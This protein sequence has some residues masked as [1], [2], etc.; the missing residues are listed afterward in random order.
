MNL[1]E[2]GWNAYFENQWQQC[3]SEDM[4]PG[5]VIADYG[6]KLRVVLEQGEVMA[7]R[8]VN[9]GTY[10]E[11][12]VVGDWVVVNCINNG[13]TAVI[14][15]VLTRKTAFTRAA[16]GRE[17]KQQVVAA[18]IEIVFLIQSLNR[19]FNL[20]RMERYLIAAWESGAIPVIVLTKAD[21]SSSAAEKVLEVQRTA[22]GTD[23]HVVS[24]VTGQGVQE[25]RRYFQPGATVALLGSSGVGKSTLINVLAGE[26][27][28][29]TQEIRLN[30]A[31]GR[32][33]TTHREII[34]LPEGGLVMDT[35]GM[36]ALQLWE[37][38]AGMAEVFGDIDELTALCRFAD[39]NHGYEPG[40]AVREALDTGV[41]GQER[42]DSWQKLQRE[43]AFIEAKKTGQA[44]LYEKRWS[45][46]IAKVSKQIK[47]VNKRK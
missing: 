47:K 31:R 33:T 25:I 43:L 10:K 45:K 17:V 3:A 4:K 20:R 7:A 21:C 12:P 16:A 38:D 1:F 34:L 41:L 44:R 37:A 46:Q 24:A 28:L 36:R 35:P 15:R 9:H 22:P 13:E 6:Q 40:C 42:W 2:F 14:N 32:H 11:T 26:E 39:C 5:R 30:D 23:I 8:P 27:L 29:T 18:N 19:D